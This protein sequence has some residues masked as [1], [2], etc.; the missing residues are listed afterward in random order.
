MFASR[1]R[2]FSPGKIVVAKV[3]SIFMTKLQKRKIP[4]SNNDK[5]YQNK[6]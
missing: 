4:S 1:D 3:H 6:K 5:N 2:M